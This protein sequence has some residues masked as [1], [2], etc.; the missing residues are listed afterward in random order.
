M[1]TQQSQQTTSTVAQ[2]QQQSIQVVPSGPKDTGG[3][4][5]IKLGETRIAGRAIA[6]FY[7]GGEA[8][9]CLPQI[10]NSILDQISLTAIHSSCDL[11]QIYCS[12]CTRDQMEVRRIT[13]EQFGS[14]LRVPG[15]SECTVRML[16]QELPN[17]P[18]T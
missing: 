1:C 14:N 17:E 4:D 13:L 18:P 2:Q 16:H 11:L 8:R 7:I 6:C 10:L 12:T 9:C 5:A 15:T 3:G